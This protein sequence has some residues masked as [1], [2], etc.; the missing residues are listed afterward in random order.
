MNKDE[1][2]GAYPGDDLPTLMGPGAGWHAESET[3]GPV[4]PGEPEQPLMGS[5]DGEQTH[6]ISGGGMGHGQPTPSFV[7]LNVHTEY[8]LLESPI[9]TQGL[10]DTCQQM[11][12]HAVAMTDNG[13]MYG[14][15]EFYLKAKKA[16]IHPIIGCEVFVVPDMSVRERGW[17][18][19]ILLA[20][21]TKGY[22]ALL[23]VVSAGH[24]RGFYYKPRVDYDCLKAASEHLIAI[25][26]GVKGPVA[27]ALRRYQSAQAETA[28]LALKEIY[29]DRFYLGLSR[30]GSTLDEV[31]IEGS[32]ALANTH[33]IPLVVTQDVMDL[34]PQQ[35]EWRHILNCI[36]TG[37]VLDE[38]TRFNE[39]D[40]YYLRSP[41]EMAALFPDFPEALANT[42]HIA[43]QCQVHIETDQINLP[44][45][46]CPNG[47]SAEAYLTQLVEAGVRHRYGDI[48]PELHT[49]MSF[50]LGII[51]QMHYAPYFLIIDDF[52]SFCR[53]NKIPV[54]PGRGS[55][56]GSLVA[57]ALGITQVDPIRYHLLFERFLNPERVSMPD[58][59]LD[60]CIR[61]RNEVI[62]Y[63]VDKYGSDRVS[64]IVT[65]GTM[66]ARGVIRDVGRV[67]NI[68]LPDVDRIA[69]LIPSAPGQSTSIPE[70]IEQIP[71]LKKAYQQS[72]TFQRW[73]D[74]GAKLEGLSRHTSTHAAGVVISRDPLSTVVPLV[75]NEDQVMTQFQ[76]TDLE[77]VGLLKMDILGLRNLTVIDDCLQLITAR[78]GIE[79]DLS[80]ISLDDARTYE[81]LSEAAT[82]GVFQLEGRGM[83]ALL[84][85]LQPRVF[86]DIIAV[87]ALYRPGPLGSGMVNAFLSNKSGET[88]VSYELPELEPILKPT[89][90]M[91]LYQEQ[92]MQIAATIAGFSLGQA[93][94][95]RKAMGKKNKVEMA[96][97]RSAF[98]EGAA[99]H[100]VTAKVAVRI[101]ELCDKFAEYGFNKSHSAAYAL[102]SYQTA[103]LKANYTVEYMTALLSSI[104]G[105]GDRT[106]VYIQDCRQ[107]GIRILPPDINQSVEGFSIIML[108]GKP[109]IRCGL[110]AVKNVGVGAIQSLIDAR[111]VPY[112]SLEDVC[113]RVDLKQANKRVLESL[114]K[115]GAMD[116]L[117]DRAA[118]LDRLTPTMDAA[119]IQAK[120]E[121]HGQMGLFG[122]QALVDPIVPTTTPTVLSQ[123]DRLAYEKE[124][125]GMYVS[126]HPLDQVADQ[127]AALPTPM[128]QLGVEDDGK[129]VTLVGLLSEVRRMVTRSKREMVMATLEDYHASMPLVVFGG[130]PGFEALA[131]QLVDHA[132]VW[133]QGKMR[134]NQDEV[135]LIVNEVRRLDE[136]IQRRLYI[137]LGSIDDPGMWVAIRDILVAHPGYMPVVLRVGDDQVLA[138]R[139]YW[140]S[141]EDA[142]RSPLEALIGRGY[143][144]VY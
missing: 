124:L 128:A 73:L 37:R 2:M 15:I 28:A 60:F 70:A 57:Y 55:A 140:V 49:R 46:P 122:E 30:H 89:Y 43:N 98:L 144:G 69:K 16:G 6:A 106:S 99:Q 127:L 86:E 22:Q 84:K 58:I 56:A 114:I 53:Q 134:V 132:V 18:R 131:T 63:I 20:M 26:P 91:I 113:K 29:G 96:K 42:V 14:V 111:T 110:G 19:L 143:F 59:D 93:D 32:V 112:A 65:F 77:K 108:D 138:N 104:L 1:T 139:R 9:R 92:V 105:L 75:K 88:P 142:W 13:V 62:Q 123:A 136:S 126:G 137:E 107:M 8:S 31:A 12:M 17:D 90:G 103:Y 80:A 47:L 135:S 48:T 100:G 115:A 24:L 117:G 121:A 36:Q 83:R 54:G 133:V 76:M 51:N 25:S 11:G 67:L 50:E 44:E 72:P 118:L 21:N 119:A 94:M 66:A 120:H 141:E 38:D 10:L 97:M 130:S 79:L 101:F 33:G 41:E 87:L 4:Y 95:L 68:P 3:D 82:T 27:A 129:Q 39:E 23:H 5:D 102:I 61:R 40:E 116:G 81:W 71:E 125:L 85:D 64:Q 78:H 34:A 74:T 109:A 52:L 45:F 35:V 7:H